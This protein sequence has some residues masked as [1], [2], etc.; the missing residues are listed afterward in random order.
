MPDTVEIDARVKRQ[1]GLALALSRAALEEFHFIRCVSP[2]LAGERLY[3]RILSS[4]F[5]VDGPAAHQLVESAR[6]SFAESATARDVR[7]CDVVHYFIIDRCLK[8]H[9]PGDAYLIDG[10]IGEVVRSVIPQHL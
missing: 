10:R 6:H 7:F 9:T 1:E 8:R 5:G 4:C 2:D 3:E